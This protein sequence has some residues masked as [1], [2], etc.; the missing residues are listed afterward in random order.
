MSAAVFEAVWKI[1]AL[2]FAAGAVW[3]ELK[4]V[5]KDIARLEQKVEKHNHF[6]RRIIRLETLAELK[7]KQRGGED[8]KV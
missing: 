4:A 5:R 3:G 2:V 7:Q 6:D 8:A 1:A